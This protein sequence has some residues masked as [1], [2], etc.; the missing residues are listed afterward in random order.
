MDYTI[1]LT[2]TERKSLEYAAVDVDE[3]LTNAGTNR[4]RIAKEEIIALNT[5]HCNANSIAIAVGE[6]AQVDQAYSLGVIKTAAVRS[7]EV[8]TLTLAN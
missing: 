6:E 1:S 8:N 7:A 5:A 4:A 2:K 3:W